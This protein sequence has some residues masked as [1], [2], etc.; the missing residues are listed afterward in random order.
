[1][2]TQKRLGLLIVFRLIN[3]VSTFFALLTIDEDEYIVFVDTVKPN[4]KFESAE[5]I[6]K[7][8]HSRKFKSAKFFWL[9][10]RES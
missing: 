8:G 9:T 6:L 5:K 4:L 7:I 2:K 3:F 1:M 10:I